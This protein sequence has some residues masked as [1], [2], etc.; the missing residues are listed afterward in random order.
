MIKADKAGREI[1]NSLFDVALKSGG[2]SNFDSIVKIMNDVE[3]LPE[4]ETEK[5]TK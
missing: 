5:E 3:D 1:L 2:M 4:K